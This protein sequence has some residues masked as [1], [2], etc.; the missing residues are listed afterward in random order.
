MIYYSVDMIAMIRRFL[1]CAWWCFLVCISH[2]V[3]IDSRGIVRYRTY[4]QKRSLVG[5][6]KGSTCKNCNVHRSIQIAEGAKGVMPRPPLVGGCMYV[7]PSLHGSVSS[8]AHDLT[9]VWMAQ[10]RE[11]DDGR[12]GRESFFRPYRS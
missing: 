10:Q 2:L 11:A 5:P 6:M 1:P 8:A 9:K 12:S 3:R 7:W 4:I